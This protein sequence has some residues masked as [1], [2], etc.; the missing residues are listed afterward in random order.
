MHVTCCYLTW[1]DG[2]QDAVVRAVRDALGRRDRLRIV[3]VRGNPREAARE[4]VDAETPFTIV[5]GG[6]VVPFPGAIRAMVRH[7][8]LRVLL[9][10]RCYKCDYRVRDPMTGNAYPGH[11]AIY[12][13]DALAQV[14]R[15]DVPTAPMPTEYRAA[16]F[17]F[18]SIQ[19]D[20]V[21]GE[22]VYPS[23]RAVYRTWF[24]A[25]IRYRLGFYKAPIPCATE[26]IFLWNNGGGHDS[27]HLY[28]A[29][30][31]RDAD[32]LRPRVEAVTCDYLGTIGSHLTFD[33]I[34]DEPTLCAA[35]GIA[36]R[37]QPM[38]QRRAA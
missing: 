18:Q 24:W 26:H 6:D 33:P 15:V 12:R 14:G 13:T 21:H 17:G 3:P 4:C 16:V 31:V 11:L 25:R 1:D 29:A 9:N 22:L 38:P 34:R 30:G 8:A 19:S 20:R 7:F 32:A 28:A 27:C 5:L 23:M 36:P 10:P 35:L 2:P 37:Q